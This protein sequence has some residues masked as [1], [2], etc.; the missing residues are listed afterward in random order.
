MTL[1]QELMSR[2]MMKLDLTIEKALHFSAFRLSAIGCFKCFCV[3]LLCNF[4]KS[5]MNKD[6]DVDELL[7][8]NY[9]A[10]LLERGRG[11]PGMISSRVGVTP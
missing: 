7:V 1:D 10:A 2:V 5:W 3:F 11:R 9:S 4:P 6:D 8:L